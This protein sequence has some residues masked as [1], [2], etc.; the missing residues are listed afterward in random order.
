MNSVDRVTLFFR[1][2]IE[3]SVLASC[4]TSL[5]VLPSGMQF[6]LWTPSWTRIF[7]PGC[8]NMAFFVYWLLWRFSLYKNSCFAVLFVR[9]NSEIIHR[10]VI[11]PGWYRFPMMASDEIKFGE[12]WTEPP[13]RGLG[14]AKKSL[15]RILQIIRTDA[16]TSVPMR[17]LTG[18]VQIR[19][20]WYINRAANAPSTALAHSVGFALVGRSLRRRPFGLNAFHRYIIEEI[21]EEIVLPKRKQA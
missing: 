4:K 20:A 10:T 7:P 16:A 12:I 1:L 8:A 17:K 3:L 21:I 14:I 15:L 18:K 13:Y 19:G 11:S 2:P 9:F 5:P 6:E